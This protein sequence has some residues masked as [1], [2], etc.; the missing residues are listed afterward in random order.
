M[1]D[2]LRILK[3]HRA[4]R[5]SMVWTSGGAR[6]HLPTLHPF[7]NGLYNNADHDDRVISTADHVHKR[8]RYPLA[9]SEKLLM[10]NACVPPIRT[11]AL[12]TLDWWA[13]FKRTIMKIPA[14]VGKHGF[15]TVMLIAELDVN[16][17]MN[18]TAS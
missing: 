9:F 5:Q 8:I 3:V 15:D 14:D 1:V 16:A 2:E 12:R 13:A 18:A 6:F 4:A 10:S 11:T 17:A 7:L